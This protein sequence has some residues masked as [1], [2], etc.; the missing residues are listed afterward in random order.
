MTHYLL[1][2]KLDQG[3][4]YDNFNISLHKKDTVICRFEWVYL[5]F[6]FISLLA[7]EL[8]VPSHFHF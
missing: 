2:D 6:H 3:I 5:L 8:S 1:A 4:K 7:L